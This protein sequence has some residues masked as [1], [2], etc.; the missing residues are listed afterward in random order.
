MT[1]TKTNKRKEILQQ[2]R[3]RRA[4]L[5]EELAKDK[6]PGE[7]ISSSALARK[8][9][10]SRGTIKNDLAWLETLRATGEKNKEKVCLKD[11]LDK[12]TNLA[13]ISE[14]NKILKEDV[15]GIWNKR[16]ALELENLKLSKELELTKNNLEEGKKVIQFLTDCNSNQSKKILELE[17]DIAE[18]AE[19]NKRITN[20]ISIATM[21]RDKDELLKANEV[22][23]EQGKKFLGERN[24]FEERAM[25]ILSIAERQT[26]VEKQLLCAIIKKDLELKTAQ[27]RVFK[28]FDI[29]CKATHKAAD[30]GL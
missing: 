25:K 19:Q 15:E 11:I 20:G 28:A 24:A 23:R 26:E 9:K 29:I 7:V 6:A 5:K 18:L 16:R 14:Q 4:K 30:E 17:A 8:Y 22:L 21:K 10:V 2:Q 3:I 27:E 1:N 13:E 12:A